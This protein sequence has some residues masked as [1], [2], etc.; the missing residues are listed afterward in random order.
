MDNPT[1]KETLE[2]PTKKKINEE[3]VTCIR[4]QE[5][6]VNPVLQGPTPQQVAGLDK[7]KGN[8]VKMN[9]KKR[10]AQ[11]FEASDRE[12]SPHEARKDDPSEDYFP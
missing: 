5:I 9:M 8:F 11:K 2:A 10:Q 12:R 7:I 3:K 6:K 1:P 4:V